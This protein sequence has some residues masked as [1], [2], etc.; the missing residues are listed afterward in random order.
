MHEK[1]EVDPINIKLY[2]RGKKTWEKIR[3]GIS[4]DVEIYNEISGI[5]I[6]YPHNWFPSSLER[7]RKGPPPPMYTCKDAARRDIKRYYS[8]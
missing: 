4:A 1:A 3:S 2:E 8:T 6:R 7:A 5:N